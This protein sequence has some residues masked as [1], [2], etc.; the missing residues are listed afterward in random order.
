MPTSPTKHGGKGAHRPSQG[1]QPHSESAGDQLA[2]PKVARV[3]LGG[4][5]ATGSPAAHNP[6]P[7]PLGESGSMAIVVVQDNGL[8]RGRKAG[9]TPPRVRR[10]IQ[11]ELMAMEV[12]G[13]KGR[14]WGLSWHTVLLAP[15]CFV[16]AFIG[17]HVLPLLHCAQGSLFQDSPY[18]PCSA[19]EALL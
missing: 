7:G 6:T 5:A 11:A 15:S 1:R 19:S 2:Q 3:V 4:S 12:V 10:C 13:Q 17:S 16:C 8:G 14:G 18:P 9:R